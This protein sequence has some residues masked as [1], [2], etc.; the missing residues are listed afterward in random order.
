VD[1]PPVE[2]ISAAPREVRF[3]LEAENTMKAIMRVFA[4]C[5]PLFVYACGGGTTPPP[6]A[7]SASVPGAPAAAAMTFAEQADMGQKL[8]ADNCAS[9][10]GA[11]GTGGKAPPLV[12]LKAGALPLNPPPNA[13]YRKTQFKTVG[14]VADFVTKNMPP[15]APGSLTPEQYWAILAFDLKANGITLD[16]KL[17]ATTAQNTTI[18]R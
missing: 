10:H 17:D 1:G 6:T 16:K 5:A 7:P 11:S 2:E 14:D 15:T 12:G 13:K 18:P 3:A 8:Y 9:C 4:A